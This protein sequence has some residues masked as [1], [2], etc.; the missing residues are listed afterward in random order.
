[1]AVASLDLPGAAG[2]RP[3]SEAARPA[4]RRLMLPETDEL[5][6]AIYTRA[7]LGFQ[8]E[9]VAVASALAREGRST[10]SLAMAVTLAQDFPDQTVVLVETDAARPSLAADFSLSASPG[11]IDCLAGDAAL[12]ETTRPTFLDNLDFVPVGGPSGRA[13]RPLRSSRMP[14]VMDAFRQTYQFVVIDTPPMLVD[15]D[16][17]LLTEYADAVLFVVR[18]GVTQAAA[19]NRAL[20]H[21]D[22]ARLRGVV[23]NGG[24][25]STPGWLRRL[26]GS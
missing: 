15:S 17:L 11:L 23:L 16:A 25:R 21:I 2:V 8:P 20:E 1:M 18:A 19:V 4:P 7:G 6:R 14:A 12:E 13:G 9:V 3:S 22:E 26:L 10:L 5:F 24:R